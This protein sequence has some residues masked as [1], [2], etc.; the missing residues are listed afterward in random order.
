MAEEALEG[1]QTKVAIS[2]LTLCLCLR[3]GPQISETGIG[4][5]CEAQQ[6]NYETPESCGDSFGRG[7]V[8]PVICDLNH[9]IMLLIFP[10]SGSKHTLSNNEVSFGPLNLLVL[11][12]P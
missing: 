9:L 6:T 3:V 5:S 10:Q 12:Y 4:V 11:S 8:R 1:F 2:I 7:V